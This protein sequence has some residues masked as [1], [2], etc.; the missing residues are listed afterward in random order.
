MMRKFS[1]I[2]LFSMLMCRLLAQTAGTTTYEFLN[3]STSARIAGLGGNQVG[4]VDN[5]VSLVFQNPGALTASLSNRIAMNFV[6]Y[7]SGIRYGYVGYARDFKSVGTFAL[8]IHNINYGNFTY[9]DEQGNLGGNFSGAEYAIMLTYSKKLTANITGGLT[10][11]PIIS[12]FEN[13]NSFGLGADV[14]FTYLSNNQNFSA[15]IALKNAGRQL[16]NYNGQL[17]NLPTDLQVGLSKRLQHAPFRF[18]LTFQ[19]LL[20]WD[21]EYYPDDS[22]NGSVNDNYDKYNV[23]TFDNIMRHTVLGVEFLPSDKFYLALGY[24]H[25]IR[26]ELKME[27]KT[28]T[29]G[30]S[31]GFGFK[32]Y[33]FNISYASARYHLAGSSNHFSL[34]ANLSDFGL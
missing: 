17:E 29:V 30:Y 18:S 22:Q 16:S 13:Y 4:L 32:V 34:T 33:K 20:N 24:N 7:I 14:G 2:I 3:L 31:W 1:L 12:N 8:G 26:Q 21:L 25:R 10:F 19:D 27:D 28:G 15:G 23:S 5:D 11:K 6:P 9:A